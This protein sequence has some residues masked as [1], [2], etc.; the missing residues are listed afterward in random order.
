MARKK[1]AY[2]GLT[3]KNRGEKMDSFQF[4]IYY[5]HLLCAEYQGYKLKNKTMFDQRAYMLLGSIPSY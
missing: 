1:E 3:E 4:I 5:K 2:E